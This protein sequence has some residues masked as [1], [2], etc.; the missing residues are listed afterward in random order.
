T[1]RVPAGPSDRQRPAQP[2]TRGAGQAEGDGA[3]LALDALQH[4]AKPEMPGNASQTPH[5]DPDRW[6]DPIVRDL[7]GDLVGA[8]F[9]PPDGA[10]GTRVLRHVRQP[11][12]E[13]LVQ[14]L[15]LPRTEP[16]KVP[17]LDQLG[18]NARQLAELADQP[19]ELIR[20]GVG[21]IL[22]GGEMAD[23]RAKLLHHDA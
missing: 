8:D 3:A 21:G 18:G 12:L 22:L 1:S 11:L 23:E 6:A 15:L 7:E 17:A 14:H 9:E 19:L 2:E 4:L 16:A 13:R 10:R 5:V 20:L